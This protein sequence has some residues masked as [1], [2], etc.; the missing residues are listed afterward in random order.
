MRQYEDEVNTVSKQATLYIRNPTFVIDFHKIAA[1]LF[2]LWELEFADFVASWN[3]LSFYLHTF[4][5]KHE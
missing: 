1:D 2:L 3:A 5:F 4:H